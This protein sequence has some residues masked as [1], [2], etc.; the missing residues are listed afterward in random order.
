MKI[1]EGD[2]LIANKYYSGITE[3]R[4][5]PALSDSFMSEIAGEKVYIVNDNGDRT[6][7]SV[8]LFTL[9]NDNARIKVY[10]DTLLREVDEMLYS[11]NNLKKKITRL[12]ETL[13]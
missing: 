4:V 13:L 6:A 9:S 5:Y 11:V 3:G 10:L 8:Y 12:Q 2:L 1:K 7:Y